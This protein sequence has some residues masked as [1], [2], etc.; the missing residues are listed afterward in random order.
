MRQR[1]VG[2]YILYEIYLNENV[3]TTPFYQLVL[4]LLSR[5]SE[6]HVSEQRL[7][8]D[9][10]H[11]VPKVGKQTPAE[12]ILTAEKTTTGKFNQDLEPYRKA[13]IENMPKTTIMNGSEVDAIVRDNDLK[14]SDGETK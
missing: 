13:H 11:S 4:D 10:L 3:K 12:F 2:L 7:L 14:A 6:L 8:A 5:S 1:L 9:F